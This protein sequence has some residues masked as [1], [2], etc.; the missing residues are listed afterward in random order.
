[1]LQGIPRVGPL[2]GAGLS[3]GDAHE[4]PG[5]AFIRSFVHVCNLFLIWGLGGGGGHN[6]EL[7]H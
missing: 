4:G 2:Q 1:M 6:V 7:V 3:Q 5:G